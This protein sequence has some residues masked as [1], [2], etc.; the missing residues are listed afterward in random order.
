MLRS[1]GWFAIPHMAGIRPDARV[2]VCRLSTST[3][4]MVLTLVAV[5]LATLIACQRREKCLYVATHHKEKPREETAGVAIA[6]C[7]ATITSSPA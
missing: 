2:T 1:A 3:V 5:L 6:S 4:K 7:M